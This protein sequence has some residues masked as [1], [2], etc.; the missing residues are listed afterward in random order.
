M[1]PPPPR[2]IQASCRRHLQ[3]HC[4]NGA[5]RWCPIDRRDKF[6]LVR[7]FCHFRC[8][9]D[10]LEGM[11]DVPQWFIGNEAVKVTDNEVAK[12]NRPG[13][14]RWYFNCN[15][16]G[17]TSSKLNSSKQGTGNP[18]SLL[19]LWLNWGL[20]KMI[21]IFCRWHFQTHFHDGKFWN[22]IIF[23]QRTLN[24]RHDFNFET[25]YHLNPFDAV[26]CRKHGYK[27][28]K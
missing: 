1:S 2:Q 24:R 12:W 8:S 22:S 14:I 28:V 20:N 15:R 23:S 6:Q 26:H 25:N 11:E 10:G 19:A 21:D 17:S 4:Q 27:W 16:L 18:V 13:L 7:C 5:G 9:L 3:L